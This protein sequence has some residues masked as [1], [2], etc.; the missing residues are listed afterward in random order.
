MMRKKCSIWLLCFGVYSVLIQGACINRHKKKHETK[1]E[2]KKELLAVYKKPVSNY[3]DSLHIDVPAA[4]FYHPDS[5]QL[6]NIKSITDSSVYDGTMHEFFYQMRNAR[7][8][9]KIN[10][11]GL[12]IIDAK[13]CRYLVFHKK[14]GSAEFIDLDTKNDAYGLFLFNLN[15][16]PL[17]VDMMNIDTALDF[18]FQE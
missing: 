10:R 1:I 4:V 16:S 9:I 5:L 11:P 17:L 6:L 15:K 18:Y 14:D 13:N 7:I 3:Q 12:K 2:A 8:V